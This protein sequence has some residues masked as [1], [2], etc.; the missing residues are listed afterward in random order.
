M[1]ATREEVDGAADQHGARLLMIDT[2][3]VAPLYRILI[4]NRLC[5]AR[6]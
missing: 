5:T 3:E 2:V 6:L 4:I 1:S